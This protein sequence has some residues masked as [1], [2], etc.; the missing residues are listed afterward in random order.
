M[1]RRWHAARATHRDALVALE[2]EAR[3]EGLQRFLDT[4][5]RVMGERR[6]SRIV[7]LVRRPL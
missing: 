5:Q 7:Y 2:G 6:L 3:F 4:V 1:A